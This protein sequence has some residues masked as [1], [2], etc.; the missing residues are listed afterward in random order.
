[1]LLC[2]AAHHWLI[3][4]I[5]TIYQRNKIIK[6]SMTTPSEVFLCHKEESLRG[7][8]FF[9]TSHSLPGIR[10]V[11]LLWLWGTILLRLRRVVLLRLR[12]VVLLR[13]RRV[14]L[15]TLCIDGQGGLRQLFNNLHTGFF[16]NKCITAFQG[17]LTYCE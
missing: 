5:I 10:G 11:V 9:I 14:V 17:N 2:A 1:M 13:L 3:T 4:E 7:G 12:R 15:L 6:Q 16:R 8:D